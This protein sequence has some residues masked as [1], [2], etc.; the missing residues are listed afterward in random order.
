VIVATFKDSSG[1]DWSLS[2]SVGSID[3]VKAEAGVDLHRI[4]TDEKFAGELMFLDPGALVRILWVL[5][6]DQAAERA[7]QPE[8]FAY[9]FDG[10]T[11]EAATEALLYGLAGFTPRSKVSQAIRAGLKESLEKMDELMVAKVNQLISSNGAGNS[12]E[13]S[14]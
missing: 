4:R 10:P 11:Q 7:I 2:I 1:R 14:A 13:Q 9:L 12:P 5:C 8:K 6:K 3:E